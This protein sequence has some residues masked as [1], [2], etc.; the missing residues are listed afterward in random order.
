[1]IDYKTV[2]ANIRAARLA[3]NIT[4]EELAEVVGISVT[5]MSHIETAASTPSLQIFVAIVNAL[6][7]SADELLCLEIA[8]AL[9]ARTNWITA[10]TDD[11]SA[12]EVKLITDMIKALKASMRR[13]GI[14]AD[15]SSF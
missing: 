8:E 9:P 3:K 15:N 12:A 5:H 10:L 7:C 13:H 2:G 11:C 4:Q 1:M 6:G 14:T